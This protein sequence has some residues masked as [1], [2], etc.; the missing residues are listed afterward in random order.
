M[1]EDE[2]PSLRIP[3]SRCGHSDFIHSDRWPRR[4][5]YSECACGRF[6]PAIRD[7][8]GPRA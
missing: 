5:L 8:R 6:D 3:C 2:M 4:C 7:G 1:E